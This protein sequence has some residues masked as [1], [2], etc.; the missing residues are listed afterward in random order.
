MG[1][2]PLGG[3]IEGVLEA[4]IE[5]AGRAYRE[6]VADTV[7]GKPSEQRWRVVARVMAQAQVLAGLFG[8]AHSAR[9]LGLL[10]QEQQ[11]S[12][13]RITEG[14]VETFAAELE[15]GFEPGMFVDAVRQF[16]NRVPR[17]R[18]EVGRLIQKAKANARAVVNAE[19]TGV[20]GV[21]ARQNGIAAQV[22]SGSFF[23]SDV[24]GQTVVNLRTLLAE[25]IRGD[26]SADEA[27]RLIG[28]PLPEFIDRAQL[29]GA[30]D[31][32]R[33][34]LQVIY[35]NNISSA[36]NEGQAE[37]LSRQEVRQIIPLVEISEIRDRRTR[38]N[39]G[40]I[41]KRGFHWQM[42]GLVGTISDI[43]DAG[44]VPPNGHN[45]R[46]TLRGIPMA[47]AKRRG[48]VNEGG[49]VDSE[50]IAR[51]NGERVDIIRR[52]DYPDPGFASAA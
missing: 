13:Q 24:D 23:V 15:T 26:V 29:A 43:R 19:A 36:A 7:E 3:S 37:Q 33:S 25:A 14:E 40:G 1:R 12:E 45:C 5:A 35:R 22:V 42:D 48:F 4:A 30:A 39:P 51:H 34:R 9:Q 28:V 38:G 20:L 32:T 49:V 2:E 47:E 17:L 27:G 10:G 50:A 11:M 52:G 41:N 44:L 16:E 46:A 31:L 18:S 6:A 21:L 8:L